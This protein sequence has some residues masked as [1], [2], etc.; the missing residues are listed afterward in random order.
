M[1]GRGYR[2]VTSDRGRPTQPASQAKPA[3]SAKEVAEKAPVVIT[4]VP[5]SADSEA[6]ILGPNGVLEGASTGS[7]VV[8]L[9]L[10][11]GVFE[12]PPP[13]KRPRG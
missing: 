8:E 13:S 5:D 4:M 9:R 10:T 11:T 2:K 3:A 1:K 7:R 6:A 12:S